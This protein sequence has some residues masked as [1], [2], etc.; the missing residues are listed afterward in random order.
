MYVMRELTG[1]SYPQIAKEFG[2]RDHTTVMYAVEKIKQQMNERHTTFDQ[3][4]ELIAR[5]KAVLRRT[6]PAEKPREALTVGNLHIDP[7][8]REVTVGDRQVTLRAKE[9]DL[10][11][12]FAQNVGMV[13]DR[14]R[15]LNLVWG[16]DYLGDSRTIVWSASTSWSRG[17]ATRTMSAPASATRRI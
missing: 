4:N 6:Q 3:V 13:L 2:G 11:L 1:F 17:T 14:E 12:T 9:F 16:F 15:L 7:A 5:I 10:L 8:R